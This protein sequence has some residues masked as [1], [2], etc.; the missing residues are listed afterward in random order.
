MAGN[1]FQYR[2]GSTFQYDGTLY[3]NGAALNITGG[4]LAIWR[5]EGTGLGSLVIAPLV[6]ANGTFR[7]TLS[8]AEAVKLPDGRSSWFI[9]Q[10][11]LAGI[12]RTYPA[13][14]IEVFGPPDD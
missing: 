4:S 6:P 9:V 2:K 14:W 11:T 7:I 8:D 5:W 1:T 13:I 10:L 12:K 3:R